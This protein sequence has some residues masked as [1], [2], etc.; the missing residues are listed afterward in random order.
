MDTKSPC[1]CEAMITDFSA[2]SVADK[3]GARLKPFSSFERPMS[4]RCGNEEEE[5]R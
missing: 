3:P 1:R 4:M 5:E 2:V